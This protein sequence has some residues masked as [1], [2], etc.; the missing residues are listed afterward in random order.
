MTAISQIERDLDWREAELAVLRVILTNRDV[1]KLQK[2][3]LFRG[4]WAL[5][6]A[7]YEGFCKFALTVYYDEIKRSGHS[8]SKFANSIQC[9][10][11]D[12]EC[13]KLKNLPTQE[14]IPA[15][16]LFEQT[17]LNSSYEFP[18]VET[19]SNL[20]PS[21]L[22]EL[23]YNAELRLPSLTTYERTIK[24]LVGR[25]NEIAHGE[26]SSIKD[27][28]YYRQHEDAVKTILYDLAFAI[29]DKL[30]ELSLWT[31]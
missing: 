12:K 13:K 17:H 2:D 10:A 16:L 11:L 7:H 27:F 22:A 25:R 26:Q 6:Y 8:L 31:K 24:T 29:D 3:V 30:A 14:F 5:L 15:L 28:E 19:D 9:F 4:A 18:D 23:V 21:K 1:T 20:W